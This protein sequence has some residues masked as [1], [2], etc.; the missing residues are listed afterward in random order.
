M[1]IIM[2][3][4][5]NF[6]IKSLLHLKYCLPFNEEIV[7]AAIFREDLYT[8]QSQEGLIDYVKNQTKYL[9]LTEDTIWALSKKELKILDIISQALEKV[10]EKI[11]WR[12]FK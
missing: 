8:F 1:Y 3:I 11:K 5:N 7:S 2:F 4:P 10:F 9:D 6:N 12:L